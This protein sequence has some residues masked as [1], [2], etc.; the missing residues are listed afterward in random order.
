MKK[1]LLLS[2]LAVTSAM[3]TLSM[4]R[5]PSA[6]SKK[7]QI[8]FL[9]NPELEV[10]KAINDKAE[11]FYFYKGH[12]KAAKIVAARLLNTPESNAW[13][14]DIKPNK[15]DLETADYFQ[16]E[17]LLQNDSQ[18]NLIK[19]E[20]EHALLLL[21]N[22]HV[23]ACRIL[24]HVANQGINKPIKAAAKLEL[25]RAYQGRYG[26]SF[27]K[28]LME[29]YAREAAAQFDNM[30]VHLQAT[31]FCHKFMYSLFK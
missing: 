22:D 21:S 30:E 10:A 23:N 27:N 13:I 5:Q 19:A 20:Y 29:K 8:D 18:Y 25:A 31:M 26:A 12:E 14:Q 2:A 17:L 15:H 28:E 11:Q 3:E 7:M 24:E 9:L 16:N 4:E 1:L 6:H